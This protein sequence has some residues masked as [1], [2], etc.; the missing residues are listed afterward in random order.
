MALRRIS[1]SSNL[2]VW[3]DKKEVYEQHQESRIMLFHEWVLAPIAQ[4]PE[5]PEHLEVCAVVEDP[6]DGSVHLLP[7]TRVYFMDQPE[8][9]S[10][11]EGGNNDIELHTGCCEHTE[12]V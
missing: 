2:K 7:Y 9:L 12:N 5:T 6:E 3:N 1:F 11:L 8:V 4:T 10:S